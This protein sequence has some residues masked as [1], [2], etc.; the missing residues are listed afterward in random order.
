MRLPLR[1]YCIFKTFISQ[2]QTVDAQRRRLSGA[3]MRLVQFRRS[4]DGD[5]IRVGVEQGEGLGV[6]DL[7]AFD[8][9]MPSTVKELLQLGDKGLECAQRYSRLNFF[10]LLP[11]FP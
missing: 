10:M 8:P 3:A 11:I 6:V 2:K 5:G 1:S 9:S 4:G 7:K